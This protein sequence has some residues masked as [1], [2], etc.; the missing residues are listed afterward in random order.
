MLLSDS[1]ISLVSSSWIVDSGA[2]HH[3]CNSFVFFLPGTLKKLHKPVVITLGDQ[4][5]V[6]A[7]LSGDIILSNQL[8]FHALFVPQFCVSLLSV[9][10]LMK[11]D[12]TVMFRLNTCSLLSPTSLYPILTGTLI[13]GLFRIFPDNDISSSSLQ[14]TLA[15]SSSQVTPEI[16]HRRFAHSG[17]FPSNNACKTCILAKHKRSFIRQPATRAS[18]PFELIHSDTCGPMPPSKSGCQYY[19]VFIDD[20]TQWTFVYFLKTKRSEECTAAFEEM[21]AFLH[22]QYPQYPIARF[23]SDNGRGEYDNNRFQDTLRNHGINYEPS[24]PRTQHKNGVSERMIQTLNARSRAMMID[25][26]MPIDFWAEAV[27]TA[28]YLQRRTT[29]SALNGKTPYEVLH[30]TKPPTNHLRR[31]GCVAY[32]RIPEEDIPNKTA[33]KFGPR[34]KQCMM[35]GYTDTTKIWRLWDSSGGPSGRGRSI[36]SSEVIFIEAK[37]AIDSAVKSNEI[38]Q[39]FQS[40]EPESTADTSEFILNPSI[41]NPELSELSEIVE[42]PV[43][44]TIVVAHPGQKSVI[45]Q[46]YDGDTIVVQAHP[47]FQEISDDPQSYQEAMN[48]PYRDQ[49]KQAMRQE[50]RALLSNHTWDNTRNSIKRYNLSHKSSAIGSRWVFKLKS[51]PD[52]SCRFKARFV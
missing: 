49:W 41:E 52:G 45:D 24:P 9:P 19:I 2:S 44:D 23:R 48:S 31:M 25:A 3:M 16:W 37:N 34:S 40:I 7:T 47:S 33:L 5:S 42:D 36:R 38:N 43:E 28:A 17:D 39:L 35:L 1:D 21:R 11:E 12:I 27:N 26:Q 4:R 50:L 51:N 30:L 8:F 46:E 10:Q 18:R 15:T 22:T 13:S 29:T 20:Y 32:H 6:I 14:A